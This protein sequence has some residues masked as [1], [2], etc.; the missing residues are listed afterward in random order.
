MSKEHI[1]KIDNS[2]T[3]STEING[4]RFP[5]RLDYEAYFIKKGSIFYPHE[6][7]DNDQLVKDVQKHWHTKGQNGCVFAQIVA[8]RADEL[9]WDVEVIR[10]T[11]NDLLSLIQAS[12]DNPRCQN[13]S[14]L[15]PEIHTV[16]QLVNTLHSLLEQNIVKLA[17]ERSFGKFV[18]LELRLPIN[19][20]AEAWLVGF[21]PFDF[22][23]KTRQA[24]QVEIALRTKTKPQDLNEQLNQDHN[25]A[26]LADIPV[27]L[28]DDRFNAVLDATKKR[29]AQIIGD[30]SR[31][32][33]KAKVTFTIPEKI[34]H[35]TR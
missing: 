9:G 23:P 25:A 2:I 27:N 26:H 14:L 15:F 8:T 31:E 33:S 1:T 34:W 16:E 28:D 20:D 24:P 4:L 10:E 29:T 18:I 35:S 19:E 3:Q 30:E 12:I 21:G 22:L 13:L 32:T 6:L 17:T 7:W 11:N 5:A